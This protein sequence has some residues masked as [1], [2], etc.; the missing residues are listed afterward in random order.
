MATTQLPTVGKDMIGAL[1]NYVATHFLDKDTRKAYKN[2]LEALERCILLEQLGSKIERINTIGSMGP[3]DKI[4]IPGKIFDKDE[5]LKE[6]LQEINKRYPQPL[7][8]KY[9]DSDG[10]V[11]WINMGSL[12]PE[13]KNRLQGLFQT[14]K[15][16]YERALQDSE[17]LLPDKG[18][19]LRKG[20]EEIKAQHKMQAIGNLASTKKPKPVSEET[21]LANKAEEAEVALEIAQMQLA[22][23]KTQ[24]AKKKVQLA[25]NGTQFAIQVVAL[26]SQLLKMSDNMLQTVDKAAKKIFSEENFKKIEKLVK[27]IDGKF[28]KPL[29]KK[30]GSDVKTGWG[31]LQP[32]L[33]KAANSLYSGLKELLKTVATFAV[34]GKVKNSNVEKA[35]S[36][37]HGAIGG[38]QNLVGNHE[39]HI[40]IVPQWPKFKD[41]LDTVK[42][43]NNPITTKK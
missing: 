40:A 30:V 23:R 18:Q 38:F 2:Y 4:I 24:L 36:L 19:A 11:I 28:M 20:I 21:E 15:E 9:D 42:I 37:L 6:L 34:G 35:R 32:E 5:E 1:S 25:E 13:D 3:V 12:L 17:A 14:F 31:K 41:L 16:R 33:K 43:P 10:P 39:K 7:W 26:N 27:D 29:L 22:E 8:T